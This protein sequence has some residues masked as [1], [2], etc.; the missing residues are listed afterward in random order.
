[1]P[2]VTTLHIV[3]AFTDRPFSGNPAAVCIGKGPV[4]ET[5]MQL[6][7]REMNLSETTFVHPAAK[8][9]F[10]LRWFT[11]AAEV[12]LCGHATLASALVLWETGV[13]PV[14]E[15]A[16][17][18]TL[19]GLLT[20]T[21]EQDWIAMDFPAGRCAP[22]VPPQGLAAA[23]GAEPVFCGQ[24]GTDLLVELRDEAAVRD[25]R[26]DLRRIAA[27]PFRGVIATSRSDQNN[28]DFVSR[29]FAP[30]VAVDEDPV[31]GSAHCT[32]GPYWAGKLGRNKLTAFQASAR[33]GTVNMEMRGE[34][35]ILRGQAVL[36]SRV[37]LR[38]GPGS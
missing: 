11:P 38:H 34:R 24:D 18:H 29:F 32:L 1:M 15:P 28:F 19:S 20:C 27:M 17:F 8:G 21:R 13:L 35:V 16:R 33:G 37:E 36:V 25:L 22:M 12:R 14:G 4:D 6:V 2:R 3:D 10:S 9:G 26:P 23:L 30:A 5:W 31:T 7:A